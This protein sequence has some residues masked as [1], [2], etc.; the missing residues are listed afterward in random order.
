MMVQNVYQKF[1]SYLL[2]ELPEQI[3]SSSETVTV[4]AS[5]DCNI[6]QE[7]RA[8]FLEPNHHKL[9]AIFNEIA[10]MQFGMTVNGN[11]W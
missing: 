4:K 5:N 1:S 2:D 7:S 9:T 3:I 8:P 10:Q 6:Q 11:L